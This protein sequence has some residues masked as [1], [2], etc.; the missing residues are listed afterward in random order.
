MSRFASL[1]PNIG[2]KSGLEQARAAV[3]STP[4]YLSCSGSRSVKV[5][6]TPRVL[7]TSI[8]PL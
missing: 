8:D 5:V 1:N 7:A 4:A 3:G 6:P 2:S